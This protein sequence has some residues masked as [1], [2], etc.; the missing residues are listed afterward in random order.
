MQR[1]PGSVLRLLQDERRAAVRKRIR[2]GLPAVAIHDDDAC[3]LK[4]ARGVDDVR[5]QRPA[6]QWMQHLGQ[7]RAHARALAGCQHHYAEIGH[8]PR[9]DMT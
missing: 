3:R 8:H 6:S 2:H 1:V 9:F 5:E 4:R 7:R